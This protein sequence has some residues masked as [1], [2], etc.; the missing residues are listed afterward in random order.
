MHYYIHMNYANAKQKKKF[1]GEIAMKIFRMAKLFAVE[2]GI[3]Q[4]KLYEL[5][6]SEYIERHKEDLQNVPN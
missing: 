1:A 6:I 4:N 2:K 3:T 5:A